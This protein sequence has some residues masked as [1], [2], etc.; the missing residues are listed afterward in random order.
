[1]GVSPSIGIQIDADAGGSPG[2]RMARKRNIALF[3]AGG[4]F[5][6]LILAAVSLVL[7][8]DVNAHKPR[9]EAALSDALGMEV[10]IGGRLGVG[11]F[12]GFHITVE[13]VRIR[14]R[15]ADV[16]SAKQT[17]LG[18]ELSPL[19]HKEIRVVKIGMRRPRISID[20]DRDGKFNFETPEGETGRKVSEG[21]EGMRFS[22]DVAKISLSDAALF[23]TDNNTGEALE[24]GVFNLEVSRLQFTGGKNAD[25]PVHLSFA[26]E[27]ACKE[28]RKGSLA[29][30]D[31]KLRIEGKDGLYKIHPVTAARLAYSGPGGKVI[32]DRIALGVDNL[33]VG[34]GGKADF[35]R[36]I[37]FSGTAGVGA[38]RTEGLVV[39]D[40]KSAVAGKDGVFDLNPVT[41][42]LFG[43]D[44]SG[45]LRADLSGAVPRYHVRYSL[46]KF[47][48]EEF[49][50]ALSP[51]KAAEGTL[52][53]SAILSMQGK[54][55][56]EMKRT[57]DGEVSLRG[58]NL[59]LNGIDLDLVFN[60]YEASQS[61]NLVDVGAF[62]IAGPF[63]PLITKGYDF[64]SLF[65]GSGGSSRIRTLLS[66]WT[67]EHGVARAKDVAM[68]TNEHRIALRGSLDFVNERFN[69]VTV[70]VVDGK[71]CVKVRQKIRGPFRKPEVEKVSILQSVAGPVLKVLKQAKKLLGGRCEVFYAGSVAPPK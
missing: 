65:R 51:K 6:L 59:T 29:V 37:S 70:A 14:N 50:K 43:G 40:L 39:S 11:L 7:F 62:F 38:I 47:R 46:S 68:A 21:A 25:H 64:A 35:F 22:L 48:I 60:R 34:G 1:M 12:P 52:S 19:L 57:A 27:F 32:A 33:A 45:N 69:D 61:F 71:G 54:T 15:G 3:A 53:L 56:N 16:A 67:V 66:D 4:F 42:R 2:K 9:L 8:V 36:R 23:Y 30:S 58:E 5:A 41:M 63:A 24:A 26:A 44:G 17:F 55:A 31:L 20:Q 13:D 18:I 10:R 49:F 28:F